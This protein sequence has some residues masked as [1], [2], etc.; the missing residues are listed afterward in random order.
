MSPFR[1]RKRLRPL[2][3]TLSTLL[4]ILAGSGAV[5]GQ[6]LTLKRE[7]PG[8]E[9][10]AC[11]PVDPA[12]PP[13]QEERTE[14]GRLGS[15]A[16]QA[17]ILGDLERARDLLSR[18]TEL[19]PTSPGLAYRHAR[20]LE[21]LEAWEEAVDAFCRVL[22]LGSESEGVGDAP[23]RLQA[24]LDRERAQIPQEAVDA[25]RDGIS[26]ADAGGSENALREFDEAR[27]LAP[28][29]PEAAYNRGIVQARLGRVEEA[30]ADLQ[31]Y[32]D[33]EPEAGDAIL[34]SQ[35]IV[36]LRSLVSLPRPSGAFTLGL[37][38]P[39][40]GQFYSGR[41]WQGLGI[42]SLA[43]GAAAAG[44]LIEE[45]TVECVGT[46]TGGDCPPD[47]IIDESTDTPYLV[48]GLA[49][50]GAVSFVG[51]LEAFFRARG[52]RTREIGALVSFNL[53]ESRVRMPTL[54]T[55]GH[56]VQLNL[57]HLTF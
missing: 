5:E 21:D 27:R 57:L 38:F 32:L 28:E 6:T 3:V 18:A 52:R 34:V 1:V 31:R 15:S 53:G 20:I 4:A 50:A 11:P 49:A 17:L 45:V 54:A 56:R 55:R 40:A 25:F 46:V 36:Q 47:R 19:D 42:L 44:F 14:A 51:A 10:F 43:A 26:E 9:S 23:A 41:A 13:S 35:R 2:P 33:L 16:D 48:Y 37:L 30:A 22:V 29:W 24:I 7:I 8:S 39:G 12:P